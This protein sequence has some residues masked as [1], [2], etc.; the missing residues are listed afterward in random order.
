MSGPAGT[1][2]STKAGLSLLKQDASKPDLVV[3]FIVEGFCPAVLLVYNTFFHSADVVLL[4][5]F[6]P[7]A[8]L[9]V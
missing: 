6:S 1:A 3:V 8:K 7:S 9:W 2:L 5:H 4:R